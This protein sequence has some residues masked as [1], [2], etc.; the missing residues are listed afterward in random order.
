MGNL[1]LRSMELSRRCWVVLVL[2]LVCVGS[3]EVLNGADMQPEE[4]LRGGSIDPIL[5]LVETGEEIRKDECAG[6]YKKFGA[7]IK[8]MEVLKAK[9]TKK[10]TEADRKAKSAEAKLKVCA[11]GQKEV[12]VKADWKKAR[13]DAKI[14]LEV[15]KKTG[16]K[17]SKLKKGEKKEVKKLK[18]KADKAVKK[19][20]KA[21]AL[22]KDAKKTEKT[23]V[24]AAKSKEKSKV[25]QVKTEIKAKE[26]AAVKKDVKLK[27]L[28]ATK[29]AKGK[30]KKIKKVK[31]TAK[32]E[33]KKAIKDEKA[34]VKKIEK[35]TVE[36]VKEAAKVTP[37]SIQKEVVKE[38]VKAKSEEQE[39]KAVKS[40]LVKES[41]AAKDKEK[42]MET[43][44]TELK[45]SQKDTAVKLEVVAKEKKA[46]DG[47][48]LEDKITGKADKTKINDLQVQMNAVKEMEPAVQEKAKA[49]ASKLALLESQLNDAKQEATK[50]DAALTILKAQ[51]S[52]GQGEL[53]SQIEMLKKESS[54]K[55][56]TI[57]GLKRRGSKLSLDK[58]NMEA[59]FIRAKIKSRT[60]GA[61]LYK[62]EQTLA[63][64]KQDLA[65]LHTSHAK[66]KDKYTSTS[67]KRELAEGRLRDAAGKHLECS[68]SMRRLK[69][70]NED[71]ITEQ[72]RKIES[73]TSSVSLEKEK[74]RAVEVSRSESK[75]TKK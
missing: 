67:S 10:A 34:T 11:D 15:E 72:R 36:K 62:T 2:A 4:L 65:N 45:D 43:K 74:L 51:M 44:Q 30:E 33:L 69:Q 75:K 22:A 60:T 56:N 48:L 18:K 37:P 50:K 19:E 49:E 66:L 61:S 29:K 41:D 54:Q 16:K 27:V 47:K 9:A 38:K 70:Y 5:S 23:K 71:T 35:A 46:Q 58:Q 20:T 7:N 1:R 6:A 59:K 13:I 21:L 52:S 17:V 32:K 55:E 73:L 28:K 57:S 64:A 68:E 53:I 26:K 63:T 14:K 31:K 8:A 24:K 12:L 25:K 3:A 42:K 40:E 39:V